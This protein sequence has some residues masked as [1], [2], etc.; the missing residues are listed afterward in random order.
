[1][2]TTTAPAPAPSLRATFKRI[3]ADGSGDF[4]RT[5][6]VDFLC[7]LGVGASKAKLAAGRILDDLQAVDDRVDWERFVRGSRK[8]LPPP[9]LDEH[10]E[11][12]PARAE[13]MFR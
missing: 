7:D 10:G 1:M 4:D 9:L 3:D 13:P 5:E 12:D 11:L 8:L 6:L 2:P